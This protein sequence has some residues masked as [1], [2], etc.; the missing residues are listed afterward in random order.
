MG[1]IK[2]ITAREIINSN[3]EPTIETK[4][5]LDS[6]LTAKA[7]VPSG[8]SVG[9]YEAFDMRDFDKKRF[10]GRGRL[11]AL[12]KVN[13][14]IG[15][16]L[17]GR[18]VTAQEMID[19]KMIELDGRADKS[20]LGSNSILS[21]SLAVARAAALEQKEE[22]YLYLQKKY[23]F[24]KISLPI[25][26][27]NF[28]NGGK[29]AD[30]NLDFQEFLYI[31]KK[32]KVAEMIRQGAEVYQSLKQELKM[33]DYD[34]D[35]GIEGGFAPE[36]N[37]SIEAL[38][39]I[40][41][42]SLRAGYEPKL[43]YY[44]GIDVGSEMLYDEKTGKY[45]FVLD[46]SYLVSETLISLYENWL[47]KYPLLYLE[48]GIAENDWPSWQK[49][50][51]QLGEK[52]LIVGDDLFATNIERLRL[53]LQKKV[54]NSIIIK[55]NQVGTL[56]ETIECIKLAQ[57][58]NYKII[59]SHRSQET[60]DDFIVDLAVAVGADYLKA[61]SLSRGERVAKYNRLLEIGQI[62]D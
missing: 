35:V 38:E 30:T 40:S 45:V 58:H 36:L 24:E 12:E 50:T 18:E 21:V 31:P 1:K 48:D 43:D 57:S 42:A 7:S 47:E 17:V 29:H 3:G 8:T 14:I 39:L 25:P 20:N 49:L 2:K 22:L 56:T 6:G 55:P 41:A 60:N 32:K 26:I 51:E 52:L 28:F 37:S 5:E 33:A 15:P 54:A 61:G 19:K 53:G 34:T 13:E 44:L 11:R 16:A 10:F 46:N 59:I 62:I 4:I 27:F 23:N 9:S